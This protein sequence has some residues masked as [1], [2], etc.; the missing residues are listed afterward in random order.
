MGS[1]FKLCAHSKLIISYPPPP[2]SNFHPISFLFDFVRTRQP[3]N[4]CPFVP[5]TSISWTT[6][7]STSSTNAI[8][9]L[10][11]NTHKQPS[12]TSIGKLFRSITK[13]PHLDVRKT[14]HQKLHHHLGVN[15]CTVS[16]NFFFLSNN[17]NFVCCNNKQVLFAQIQTTLSSG[18]FL[19]LVV[20]LLKYLSK[21]QQERN[22]LL[23][24]LRVMFQQMLL[25]CD[26]VISRFWLKI[27]LTK[28]FFTVEVV[29]LCD[30][31]HDSYHHFQDC[32]TAISALKYK[33]YPEFYQRLLLLSM[34]SNPS[35]TPNSFSQSFWKHFENKGIHFF[36]FNVKSILP[37]LDELKKIAG[38]TKDA[39][40]IGKTVG[41]L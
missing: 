19:L 2:P 38:N 14:G 5:G 41:N 22:T 3:T 4:I 39:I 7:S 32:Y 1:S 25:I 18:Y 37:Q 13:L 16:V 40:I 34:S 28:D 15:S 8:K 27:F 21:K 10:C 35:F 36:H 26:I 24:K 11:V 33:N 29:D 31:L 6:T 30:R 20:L 9:N 17:F 12:P 23:L